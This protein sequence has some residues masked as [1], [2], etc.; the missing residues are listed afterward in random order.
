M[1]SPRNFREFFVPEYNRCFGPLVREGYI[2]DF[3][4]CGCVQDIVGDIIKMHVTILNPVQERANDLALIKGKCAG[5]MALQGAIDSQ[6]LMLGPVP[7]I[8]AEVKRVMG[9]LGG[10]GGYIVGPDQSLPFPKENIDSL[11]V[12]AEE[13]GRYPIETTGTP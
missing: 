1:I 8:Q 10:G 9:I 7:K 4:S 12:A 5:K 6:L 3:H 11:W 2:I 13:F